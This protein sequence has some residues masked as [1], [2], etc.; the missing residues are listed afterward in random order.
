MAN[1]IDLALVKCDPR[2]GESCVLV[3]APWL[4]HLDVGM[5]V[6]FWDE[7]TL[8]GRSFEGEIIST[9]DIRKDDEVLDFIKKCFGVA[10]LPKITT[11]YKP[12]KMKYEDDYD[13]LHE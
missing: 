9:I 13:E 5:R 2:T 6:E 1:Y 10:K 11:V 7:T 12:Y 3:Q 4:S 8:A